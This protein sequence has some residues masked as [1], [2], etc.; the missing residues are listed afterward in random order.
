[1][2]SNCCALTHTLIG[3]ERPFGGAVSCPSPCRL[4]PGI[5]PATFQLADDPLYLLNT[6]AQNQ[7]L[8]DCLSILSSIYCTDGLDPIPEQCASQLVSHKE[9]QPFTPFILTFIRAN[10]ESSNPKCTSSD[11]GR[12]PEHLE[13]IHAGTRR[14]CKHAKAQP[15]LHHHAAPAASANLYNYM[16]INIM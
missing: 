7:H 14:T 10:S 13:R 6:A 3:A 5:E 16:S 9:K 2:P 1:M 12:K 4:E 11:C 8:S 15:S